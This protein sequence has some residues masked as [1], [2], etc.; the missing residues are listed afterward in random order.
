M[1]ILSIVGA[2]PQFIKASQIFKRLSKDVKHVLVHTG[3]HYDWN[4]SKVFFN[5]LSI[6]KIRLFFQFNRIIC[7]V[8]NAIK[9]SIKKIIKTE[10]KNL[11]FKIQN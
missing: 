1:K 8:P 5:E 11:C 2:R 9:T 7:Q 4:M 6:S 3:Q 10:N